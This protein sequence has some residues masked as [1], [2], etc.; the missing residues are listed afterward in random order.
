MWTLLELRCFRALF[1]IAKRKS[2]RAISRGPI[3]LVDASVAL[4]HLVNPKAEQG[5]DEED[6]NHIDGS[7]DAAATCEARQAGGGDHWDATEAWHAVDKDD[8]KEVEEEV[9]KGNLQPKDGAI[10]RER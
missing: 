10:S 1:R 7:H 5:E 3:L 2:P 8:A 6:T 4:N 9:H